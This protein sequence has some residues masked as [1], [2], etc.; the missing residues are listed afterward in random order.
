MDGVTA[1]TGIDAIVMPVVRCD[2]LQYRGTWDRAV[3]H[4]VSLARE[5]KSFVNDYS[6]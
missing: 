2:W 6:T 4:G 3:L 1:R 5:L